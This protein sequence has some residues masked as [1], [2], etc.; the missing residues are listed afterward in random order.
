MCTA[1]SLPTVGNTS[2]D[3]I[4]MPEQFLGE[5]TRSLNI[6]D[7]GCELICEA[8]VS[9]EILAVEPIGNVP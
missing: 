5:N 7:Q 9:D 8:F 6:T 3:A 2:S 1:S 4:S